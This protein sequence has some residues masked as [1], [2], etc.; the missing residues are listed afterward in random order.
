MAGGEVNAGDVL[1]TDMTV[2]PAR[3]LFRVQEPRALPPLIQLEHVTKIYRMGDVTVHG[4]ARRL[5]DD[6]PKA[7]SW[8]SWARRAPGNRR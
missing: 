1:I 5:A 3:G 4:L 2:D 8:P 7:S 6:Q